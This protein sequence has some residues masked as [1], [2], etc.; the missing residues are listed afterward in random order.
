[1]EQKVK[2]ERRLSGVVV[3]AKAQKTVTVS[4]ERIFQHPVYKKIVRRKI[5]YMVHDE[6]GS[7]K[8]G[9]LVIIKLVRP[10]SKTKRWLVVDVKKAQAGKEV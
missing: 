7:C 1:M 2:V 8:P 5:R 9:D 3:T 4:V 10:L 6:K